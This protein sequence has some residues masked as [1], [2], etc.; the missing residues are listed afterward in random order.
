MFWS[1]YI[2]GTLRSVPQDYSIAIQFS[3]VW[4]HLRR[5]LITWK[6]PVWTFPQMLFERTGKR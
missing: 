4:K 5:K 2:V 1:P 6:E 3:W